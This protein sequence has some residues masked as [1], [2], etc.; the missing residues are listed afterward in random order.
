MSKPDP[1]P[2]HC[3]RATTETRPK[4]EAKARKA[5]FDNAVHA[6]I[7]IIDVDCWITGSVSLKADYIVI[8]PQVVDIV[9]ELKGSDIRHAIKQVVVTTEQWRSATGSSGMVGGLVIC[10]H[11][12]ENS[13]SLANHKKKLRDKNRIHLEVDKNGKKEYQFETFTG[14]KV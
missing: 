10:T 14:K 9:V 8:K 4:V 12:P 11:S 13:A 2:E 6:N 5:V 3:K 7:Q 1:V